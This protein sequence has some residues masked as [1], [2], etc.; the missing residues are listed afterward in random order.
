MATVELE[1]PET[2]WV[3]SVGFT[4]AGELRALQARDPEWETALTLLLAELLTQPAPSGRVL[5]NHLTSDDPDLLYELA[6]QFGQRKPL[7]RDQ[8][9]HGY[10][11]GGGRWIDVPDEPDEPDQY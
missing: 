6:E 5:G 11:A 4:D 8:R 3:G 2:G 7:C 9:L 1:S 10:V